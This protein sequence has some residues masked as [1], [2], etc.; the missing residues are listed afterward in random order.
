M[1]EA[2]QIKEDITNKERLTL[3]DFHPDAVTYDQGEEDTSYVQ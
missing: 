1:V 2:V 3:K